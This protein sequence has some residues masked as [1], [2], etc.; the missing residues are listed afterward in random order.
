[1]AENQPRQVPREMW[2]YD[3]RCM[4]N[5]MGWLLSDHSAYLEQEAQSD[6][7]SVMLAEMSAEDIDAQLTA[8]WQAQT[9]VAI[10]MMPTFGATHAAAFQGLVLGHDAAQVFLQEANG[11]VTKLDI[12]DMRHVQQVELA[13]WWAASAS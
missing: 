8:A 13:H 7:P 5:W 6:Q 12:A 4:M 1:M 10:Q 11:N 3:D 9:P 2:L